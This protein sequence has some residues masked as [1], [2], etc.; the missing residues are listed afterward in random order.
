MLVAWILKLL[1]WLSVTLFIYVY[2]KL[3]EA[4]PALLGLLHCIPDEAYMRV[5]TASCEAGPGATPMCMYIWSLYEENTNPWF[6]DRCFFWNS[7]FGLWKWH[8]YIKLVKLLK[9]S[10]QGSN[11]RPKGNSQDILEIK[12]SSARNEPATLG[13]EGSSLHHYT[14][15]LSY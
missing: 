14:M 6:S 4:A 11:L 12:V 5:I 3:F 13:L 10:C 15:D 9:F 8:L 7:T 2:I 1:N